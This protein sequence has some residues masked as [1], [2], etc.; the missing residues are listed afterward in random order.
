MAILFYS[1]EKSSP[2]IAGSDELSSISYQEKIY[3][4]PIVVDN[5]IISIQN[6]QNNN[7]LTAFNNTGAIDWSININNYII[8]GTNYDNVPY[9]ILSKNKNNEIFLNFFSE[10]NKGTE[11][12]KTIRFSN[13]GEYIS[14][15]TDSIH[16]NIPNIVPSARRFSGLG[17][18][19]LDN[20]NVAVVSSLTAL[21]TQQTFIQMSEYNSAGEY[22]NDTTYTIDELFD[23]Y[24]V[25][26]ASNGNLVFEAGNE[27]G[28]N[29]FVIFNPNNGDVFT[30]PELP[31]FDLLSFYE[32]SKG[33]FIITASAFVDNLDYYGIIISISSRA[34]YLW[35]QAYTDQ[36]AWLLTSVREVSDGYI[37]T[38]FDITGQL[39]NE[40]DWRSSLDN[41]KVFGI[42]MKTD[43]NGKSIKTPTGHT[44]LCLRHQQ[45]ALLFYKT[46]TEIIPFWEE[47]MT[48]IYTAL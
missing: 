10:N 14:Q 11:L 25:F 42:V 18:L 47:N 43:F 12:I 4:Q 37:F 40:F 31:I 27:F 35:H 41:E 2:E 46:K 16:Q 26:L 39:L 45:Q 34:E 15:F 29:R 38:G 44:G 13:S 33:D 48:A 17:I 9:L 23:P 3:A 5:K 6:K 21:S 30:S 7:F 32:N 22:L 36:T 24:Q 1:C 19:A 20:G 28:I 8:S